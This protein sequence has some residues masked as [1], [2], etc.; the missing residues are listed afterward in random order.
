M[1]TLFDPRIVLASGAGAL[2]SL[3]RR[4]ALQVMLAH[5]LVVAPLIGLVLGDIEVGLAVGVLVGL[6]WSGALPVGGVVPPDETLGAIVG[7]AVAILAGRAAGLGILSSSMIGFVFALPA[8][9]VGRRIELGLR[10][11]NGELAAK[12]EKA[13]GA[14]DTRAIERTTA[15]A[16]S[17]ALGVAFVT[18]LVMLA[19]AVPVVGALLS[20]NPG[21]APFLD[22]AAAPIPFAGLGGVIVGAGFRIGLAWATLGFAL[23]VVFVE[24][25]A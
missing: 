8:A 15:L 17:A 11:L 9:V 18:Q 7:T 19:I 21:A 4:A 24:V 25:R 6:L 23:G 20:R 1:E 3:D 5:P 22:A 16:L 13:V 10:R 14:G 12:A 2:L